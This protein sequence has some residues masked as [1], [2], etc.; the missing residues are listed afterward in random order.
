MVYVQ[1]C[2]PHKILEMK[3]PDEAY[4]GKRSNVGHF[5]IF[6]SSVYFHVTKDARKNLE[7]TTKL[8]I[9]VGCT[10]T[11]HIYLVYLPTSKMTVVHR[12]VR[13]DEEKAM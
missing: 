5:K 9:F 13:F 1:N 6:G 12:D 4:C 10:D 2:S 7:L 11:P 3:T 8:G